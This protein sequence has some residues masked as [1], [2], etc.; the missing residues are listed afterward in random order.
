MS[1][2]FTLLLGMFALLAAGCSAKFPVAKIYCDTNADCPSGSVCGAHNRCTESFVDASLGDAALADAAADA[3]AVVDL[4]SDAASTDAGVDAAENDA[5]TVDAAT[6][7]AATTDANTMD[8]TTTDAT[9]LDA[10]ATDAAV[11]DAVVVDAIVVTDS[12]MCSA[13]AGG[14]IYDLNQCTNELVYRDFEADSLG[15]VADWPTIACM[16]ASGPAPTATIENGCLSRNVALDFSSVGGVGAV[17][18]PINWPSSAQVRVDFDL[19]PRQTSQTITIE[20]VVNGMRMFS[21]TPFQAGASLPDGSSYVAHEWYHVEYIIDFDTAK[22]YLSINNNAVGGGPLSYTSPTCAPSAAIGMPSSFLTIVGGA[23]HAAFTADIDNVV[24]LPEPGPTTL[25]RSAAPDSP[26]R[27]DCYNACALTDAS[28]ITSCITMW[29]MDTMSCV[30]ANDAVCAARAG[31]ADGYAAFQC[32]AQALCRGDMS[33]LSGASGPCTGAW[34]TFT[35]CAQGLPSTTDCREVAAPCFMSSCAI[36]S[37]NT[38]NNGMTLTVPTGYISLPAATVELW[39]KVDAISGN[40]F[41]FAGGA[42]SNGDRV[43]ISVRPNGAVQC[44]LSRVVAGIEEAGMN[45]PVAIASAPSTVRAG[46][47][48]HYAC[49]YGPPSAGLPNQL[50]FFLDGQLIGSSMLPYSGFAL[51]SGALGLGGVPGT[52]PLLAAT[53]NFVGEVDEVRLSSGSIYATTSAFTPK[54]RLAVDSTSTLLLWHFD[55][56]SGTTST[57]ATPTGLVFS[58]S[59][60]TAGIPDSMQW[61]DAGT[62]LVY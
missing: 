4:G 38:F 41:L 23:T 50:N 48:H 11:T 57:A 46:E 3:E 21:S 62:P 27:F 28:C 24:V 14:R 17:G 1:R 58:A 36:R 61:L 16:G 8:A 25:A 44:R 33:C 30:F 18:I 20:P 56:C 52:W 49:E 60:T 54:K 37:P 29:S 2:K 55:E 34:N 12:G 5:S 7:D 40:Q 42:N 15:Q 51:D 35:A 45:A 31:C 26:S 13:D 9:V 6:T 59:F 32:C 19:R 53:N 10:S 43:A 47:W 39:G 22:Y